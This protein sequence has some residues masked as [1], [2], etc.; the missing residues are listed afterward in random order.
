[1]C[2]K[3]HLTIEPS[4]FSKSNHLIILEYRS[5]KTWRILNASHSALYPRPNKNVNV[6]QSDSWSLSVT[7]E[8][9]KD[10]VKVTVK[11][12]HLSFRFVG[13]F[14]WQWKGDRSVSFRREWI[15][16]QYRNR[17][18]FFIKTN[19]NLRKKF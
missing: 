16:N 15:I 4:S 7:R 12:I 11:H 5:N 8:E 18:L 19:L 3:T 17:F 10:T 2:Y 13:R 1:M 6:Q 14:W 9:L